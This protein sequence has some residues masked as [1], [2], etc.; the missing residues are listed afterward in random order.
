[1]KKLI[2]LLTVLSM[3]VAAMAQM[4]IPGATFADNPSRFDGR[5]V[6]VKGV[7]LESANPHG[8]PIAVKPHIGPVAPC[9]PPRGF[10]QVSVNFIS[11]PNYNACFF[12]QDPMHDALMR[13]LA[14][15][16]IEA[17]ITFR[18]DSRIGYNVTF[19]RLK[20]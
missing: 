1:M 5:K 12:M 10:K 4:A 6:T 15:R 16:D 7:M 19:Y 20:F 3:S 2:I 14:S 11:A 9:N 13:E 8:S 18:G 17:E